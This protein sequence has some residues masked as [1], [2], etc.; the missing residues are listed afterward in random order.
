L[1]TR[2]QTE[3]E[4]FARTGADETWG[5]ADVYTQEWTPVSYTFQA[6]GSYR[7]SFGAMAVNETLYT[8][9]YLGVDNARIVP[10]EVIPE[11]VTFAALAGSLVSL[12][13]YLRRRDRALGRN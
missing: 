10:A 3:H 5:L 13:A 1:L 9:T 11:P 2:D 6:S 8:Q 4:I 7:L 12:G